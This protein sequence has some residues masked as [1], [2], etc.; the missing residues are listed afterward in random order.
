[1]PA[2]LFVTVYLLLVLVR[3]QE[4]PQMAGAGIPLL[5]IALV[6]ALLAWLGSR[7]KRF[8][9]PQYLILP[10]FVLM[11][12]LSIALNGW[13]GGAVEH[14]TL[15]APSLVAFVVLANSTTTPARMT[16][17]M[18]VFTGSA[19]LMAIHGV[20]QK[21]TGVGWTGMPLVD[22]G[23]I[24]YLGIFS[25][26]NDLAMLFV[27]CLPMALFLAARGGLLGVRRLLWLGVAGL[28]LYG[29]Y[30]TNSR[31]GMLA[32]AAMLGAFLWLRRGPASALAVAAAG[33][34]MM[35]LLPSRLNE[36]D[37]AERSASGR[38]EA[39]YEGIQMFIGSPLYGVGTGNFTNYHH[40]TAHN[41]LVLV[42][43]E[44]G[45]IGFGLW[46]A[47]IGYCFWMMVRILRQAPQGSYPGQQWAWDDDDPAGR[48]REGEDEGES[49]SEAS[50]PA[51]DATLELALVEQWRRDRAVATTKGGFLVGFASTTFF[52]SRSY[53][54][55]LY[56]LAAVVVAHST[57]VRE[58]FPAVPAFRLGGDMIRWVLLASLTAA[59]FYV[60]LRLLLV[61]S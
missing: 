39:W 21:S 18:V 23:R 58:R 25:D 61:M 1:M 42:L 16:W 34:V 30:L 53:I 56:L 20:D 11:T 35:R 33:L 24:Q 48:G 2:F 57:A 47:F 44:N 43:A 5:P 14:F 17:A 8:D 45:I 9:E 41:S 26:P 38:V 55:L 46:F 60:L 51:F 22:D 27:I 19:A 6:C 3:P 31:G 50:A 52:L 4:Y 54:I 59:G 13:V 15:F 36:L 7:E 10:V 12:S 40:L 28:L 29:I 37:V 32:V 49:E